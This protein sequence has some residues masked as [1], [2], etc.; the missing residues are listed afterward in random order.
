MPSLSR[1]RLLS[2][3]GSLKDCRWMVAANSALFHL[4][5]SVWVD[6]FFDF[7]CLFVVFSWP[8]CGPGVPGDGADGSR[9][10]KMDEWH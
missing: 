10:L 8:T 3:L 7:A 6:S 2:F 4:G 5:I 1:S 9:R